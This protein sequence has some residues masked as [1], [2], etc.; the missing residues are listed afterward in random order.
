MNVI[1]FPADQR[2]A[3]IASDYA[4]KIG[5]GLFAT[6]VLQRGAID[7]AARNQVLPAVAAT[8]VVLGPRE[9]LEGFR[10]NDRDFGVACIDW[11]SAGASP[12]HS[13]EEGT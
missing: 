12:E 3:R 8:H 10:F 11:P 1:P 5:Y 6:Q 7:Y 4:H 2:T 13:T 9:T